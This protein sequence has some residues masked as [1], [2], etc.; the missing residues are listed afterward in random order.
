MNWLPGVLSGPGWAM[1]LPP[2]PSIVISSSGKFLIVPDVE[3]AATAAFV[4]VQVPKLARGTSP[5]DVD[6]ASAIHSALAFWQVAAE[7][8]WVVEKLLPDVVESATWS[9]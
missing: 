9:V 7:Q 6:G 2:G 1:T 5:L 3:P 4:R 8:L